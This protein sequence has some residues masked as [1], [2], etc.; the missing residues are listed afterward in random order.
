MNKKLTQ[1]QCQVIQCKKI[2]DKMIIGKETPTA[3]C[4]YCGGMAVKI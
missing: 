1:Y 4:P 2:F 3:I